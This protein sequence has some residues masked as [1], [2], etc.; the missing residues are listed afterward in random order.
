MTTATMLGTLLLDH[1]EE[2]QGSDLPQMWARPAGTPLRNDGIWHHWMQ[3]GVVYRVAYDGV[4]WRVTG[5][6][7]TDRSHVY[8]LIEAMDG[9]FVGALP[10]GGGIVVLEEGSAYEL[11]EQGPAS[12]V[13]ELHRL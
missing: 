6:T 2:Q 1:S 8:R 10:T 12:G 3:S 4:G 13:W 9:Q 7:W 5:D 11:R